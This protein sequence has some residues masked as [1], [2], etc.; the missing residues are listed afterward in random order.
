MTELNTIIMKKQHLFLLSISL[1][2]SIFSFSQVISNEAFKLSNSFGDFQMRRYISG[3]LTYRRALV[4]SYNATTQTASLLINYAGDFTDG[5]RVMGTKTV[6]DGNLLIGNPN[7]ARTEINTNT[8]HKIF[9]PTNF[10]TIDLDGNY[11]GGGFVG[12]YRADNQK[13]G[14]FME[15]QPNLNHNALIVRELRNDLIKSE[16]IVLY[17]TMFSGETEPTNFISLPQHKSVIVIGESGYY[18][19][20]Q[21]YGLINKLKTSFENDV[22]VET[23][24]VGIGTITPDSGYKLTVKGKISTREVKVT[25]T[26]GGADFVF[27]DTYKLPTLKT[28]EQFIAKNK[29]LPE[30]ASAKEMEKNGIHLAEMNIK[31]LQKIEELTLYTIQQQKELETQQIALEAQQQK[32]KTLEARLEA[33][34]VHLK[35]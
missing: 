7:G 35:N 27:E 10:K 28:V 30:I 18:K 2:L 34:E 26:A 31:L 12:V 11:H 21:N 1:M 5:V 9:A 6:F 32:N 3:D 29:H 14:V 13:R 4:P 19:R 17:S 20:S 33:L 22:Y 8:N 24:N 23:G 25:A 15:S 16:G